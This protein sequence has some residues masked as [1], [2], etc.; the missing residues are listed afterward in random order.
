M[1]NLIENGA[2]DVFSNLNIWPNII[3][4]SYDNSTLFL[5]FL[6]EILIGMYESILTMH[7]GIHFSFYHKQTSKF[8]NEVNCSNY[9]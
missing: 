3:E 8:V 6:F 5:W 4:F 1:V 7:I 2:K 9:T